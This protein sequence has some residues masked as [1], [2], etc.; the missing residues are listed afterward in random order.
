MARRRPFQ[1]KCPEAFNRR[2]SQVGPLVVVPG[3][4]LVEG[5]LLGS[6]RG[7]RWPRGL[8]LE[9]AVKPLRASVLLRLA[10]LD[11][12]RPNSQLQPP[13]RQA[14]EAPWTH[15]SEGC[16][17]VGAHARGK[18]KLLEGGFEDP[19]DEPFV[20]TDGRLA[21][22]QISAVDIDDRQRIADEPVARPKLS[23]EIHA[24]YGVGPIR[25][26]R[27]LGR[28]RWRPGTTAATPHQPLPLQDAANGTSGRQLLALHALT[29][30]P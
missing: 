12:L 13:D 4:E 26:D 14:A 7:A 21:P 8:T 24:P 1:S 30:Q 19:A 20:R 27:W 28:A 23:L 17:V 18:A 25:F 16:A 15:R 2:R 11:P 10:R 29:Y 9:G 22:D 3:A 6:Q 5:S